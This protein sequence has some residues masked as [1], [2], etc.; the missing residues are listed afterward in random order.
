MLKG[1]ISPQLQGK[2]DLIIGLNFTGTSKTL[3]WT[4]ITQ[5]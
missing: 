3:F 4:K 2:M 1:G 5:I